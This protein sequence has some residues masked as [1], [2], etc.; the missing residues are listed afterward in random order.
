[1]ATHPAAHRTYTNL[2]ALPPMAPIGYRVPA[3][4][5]IYENIPLPWR[6]EPLPMPTSAP[7]DVSVESPKQETDTSVSLSVAPS[8]PATLADTS[9]TS[10]NTT[11]TGRFF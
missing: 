10:A 5:P 7:I 4:E 1:M 8:S 9:V 6:E 2:A 3:P 11:S